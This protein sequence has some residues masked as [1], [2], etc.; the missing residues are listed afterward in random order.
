MPVGGSFS[1]DFKGEFYKHGSNFAY[2]LFIIITIF[3]SY[4]NHHGVNFFIDSFCSHA[5]YILGTLFA[6]WL[7]MLLF[8]KK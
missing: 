5:G 7:N 2:V 1:E 3:F 8:R 6:F 4:L